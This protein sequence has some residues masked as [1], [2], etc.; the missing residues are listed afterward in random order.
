MVYA[1]YLAMLIGA[2]GLY[3]MLPSPRRRPVVLGVLL[4]LGGLAG[5]MIYL[6]DW[7]G[8]H[9][10]TIYYYAFTVIAIASA[11]RVITHKR[12]VYSALYFILVVLAVAGQFL[13][14][15]AEFMA[16][17]MVI[18]YAGAILVTYVF[19]I[20]LATLPRSSHDEEEA[21][22]YDRA[23]RQPLGAVLMGF[24]L[25]AVVLHVIFAA[26]GEIERPYPAEQGL[27]V[28]Q[29]VPGRL[30]EK[31][32]TT[33]LRSAGLIEKGE[34][35]VAVDLKAGSATVQP[36]EDGQPT[37]T[38]TIPE[39]LA[40]AQVGNMDRVGLNLFESHT[41]GI[42][43]AGVILLLA[44]VGAIVIARIVVKDEGAEEEGTKAISA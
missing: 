23:A 1:I 39:Q 2:A 17:A 3:L 12:P 41:L 6:L 37:R 9:R 10:P 14:L 8:E 40:G 44:M 30:S 33:L 22:L 34:K 4:G 16:F 19:V 7:A 15:E 38:V 13:L 32:L 27:A 5:L 21:P 11:V 29:S 20:M 26:P 42:E 18:I 28:V 31:K 36:V 35:V 25:L 24:A 43:L